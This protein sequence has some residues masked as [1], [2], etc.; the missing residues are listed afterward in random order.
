[1]NLKVKP[2]IPLLALTLAAS[3]ALA[4]PNAEQV[5][6][7]QLLQALSKQQQIAPA[8]IP[9][10]P[11]SVELPPM[12]E[13]QQAKLY[14]SWP[15]SQSVMFFKRYR[16][17]FAFNGTRHIDPDGQIVAYQFDSVTGDVGYVVKNGDDSALI[18]VMRAGGEPV[19]L[20]SGVLSGD[21]WKFKTVSG[22]TLAGDKIIPL[23]RGFMLGRESTG[24]SY[25]FGEGLRSIAAPDGFDFAR[26]QN[27]DMASTGYLLLER[28]QDDQRITGDQDIDSLIGTVKSLGSLLGVTKKEDYL[29][30]NTRNNTTL[31]INV[32]IEDKNAHFYSGCTP[33]KIK[34]VNQCRNMASF[35]SLFDQNGRP[36]QTHYFW[37]IQWMNTADG[38][39]LVAQENG[40]RDIT[41][42]HLKTTQRATV[43]N[44]TLGIA[45][46]ETNMSENGKLRIS[47]QMG[48]SRETVD[49]AFASMQGKLTEQQK[50]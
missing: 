13:Q 12:S 43:L 35:D 27:G 40:L 33:S 29:L 8:A 47:A 34:Y 14:A 23:S 32:S 16:D 5:Q 7:L 36:N 44:R 26:F 21:I 17:G 18:K 19:S 15:K 49:D 31:P 6:L 28:R 11:A 39:L 24:F 10:S 25:L 48:F 46:F 50:I 1:M 2:L 22:K 9:A 20:A 45:S 38:P 3:P 41:V 42:T 4:D 30:L 37:R